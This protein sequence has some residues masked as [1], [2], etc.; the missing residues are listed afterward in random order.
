MQ[1]DSYSPLSNSNIHITS[2]Y[3]VCVYFSY[4]EP[5][6]YPHYSTIRLVCQ[7]FFVKMRKNSAQYTVF[8]SV[9][10]ALF[11]FFFQLP[12]LSFSGI[13]CALCGTLYTVPPFCMET[14]RICSI[15]TFLPSNRS[16]MVSTQAV[17]SP[18][19]SCAILVSLGVNSRV[20]STAS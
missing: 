4:M 20:M 11:L 7:Y 10:C 12:Y 14:G 15:S 18:G 19:I 16:I 9:Y 8:Y 1:M 3:P 17:A 6:P 13:L 2:P 5:V